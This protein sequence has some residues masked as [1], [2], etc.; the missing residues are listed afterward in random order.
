MHR[1]QNLQRLFGIGHRRVDQRR[2]IR[3]ALSVHITRPGIPC[4]RHHRLIVGDAFVFDFYPVP[5]R[6]ARR[7]EKPEPA[8]PV[9]PGLGSHFSPL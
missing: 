1:A 5:Q 8:R 2:L 9:R 6:S 3:A 4:G 7:L